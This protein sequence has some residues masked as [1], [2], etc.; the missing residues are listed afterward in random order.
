M[1]GSCRSK[2]SAN[3][4]PSPARAAFQAS[5]SVLGGL[6]GGNVRRRSYG[7]MSLSPMI[8]RWSRSGRP[9]SAAD[10]ALVALGQARIGG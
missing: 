2:I 5:V 6:T 1:R 9:G 7:S 10:P 4:V 3:A 8:P